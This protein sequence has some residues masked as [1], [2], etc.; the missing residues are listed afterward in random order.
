M[1]SNNEQVSAKMMKIGNRVVRGKDWMGGNGD[2]NG[3]GTIMQINSRYD[4]CRVKWDHE[5]NVSRWYHQGQNGE[6]EL[7]LAPPRK[8][9][10]LGERLFK[11]KEYADAKIICEGKTF[12]CHKIILSCLSDVFAAMF[13]NESMPEANSGVI[14]IDDFEAEVIETMIYFIY[15]DEIQEK[16]KITAHL[17]RAADKYNIG[18]LVE[19]CIQHFKLNFSSDTVLDI[20]VLAHLMDE[21]ELFYAG[22][23][24]VKKNV[25]SVVKTK[26]WQQLKETNP[27]LIGT[28]M[29]KIFDL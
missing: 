23:D 10:K 27:A 2:G 17:L 3:E 4:W 20:L 16:N 26:D 24:F 15:N 25:G 28:I 1:T 8:K 18:D 5:S 22:A 19:F 9:Q 13:K 29:T 14:K 7:K 21:K 6:F 11:E 12:E